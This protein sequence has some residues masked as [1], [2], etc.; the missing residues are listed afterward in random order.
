LIIALVTTAK[1]VLKSKH[2]VDI[3]F[4]LLRSEYSPLLQSK[5]FAKDLTQLEN[6]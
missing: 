4:Q 2:S 5:I 6:F 1:G 3:S